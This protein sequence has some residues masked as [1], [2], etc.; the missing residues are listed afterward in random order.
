MLYHRLYGF[1]A[2]CGIK[3]AEQEAAVWALVP[4]KSLYP[5]CMYS[6]KFCS[7]QSALINMFI[8]VLLSV[9]TVK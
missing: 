7:Y 2:S 5:I 9:C 8:F 3:A 6:R 4:S 1:S